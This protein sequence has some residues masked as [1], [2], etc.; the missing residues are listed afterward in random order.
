MIFPPPRFVVVDD[1]EDHL[2]AIRR[3]FETLGAPCL[4]I[5]YKE[6]GMGGAAQDLL[7]GVRVLCLDLHLTDPL[8]TTDASRHYGIIADLLETNISKTGGPFM[9]VVWTAHEG[10][11]EGLGPYLDSA[12]D[13]PLSHVRPLKILPLAKARFIDKASGELLTGAAASLR[14]SLLTAVNDVPQ[15]AALLEWETDTQAATG[16]TLSALMESVPQD[17]RPIEQVAGGLGTVLAHLG[18][19]AAGEDRAKSD[20]RAAVGSA[21]VPLLADRMLHREPADEPPGPW[22]AATAGN[23]DSSLKPEANAKINRMV[24]LAPSTDALGADAWG[25]VVDLPEAWQGDAQLRSR[26]GVERTYL[27]RQEF[28]LGSDTLKKPR[29]VRIGAV[30]DYVLDRPGPLTYLLGA[31][32]PAPM[33]GDKPPASVWTSPSLLGASDE[34]PFELRFSARFPVVATAE[35]V[36]D[37]K[38]IYRLREQLL[39]HLVTHAGSYLSRPGVL[40]LPPAIRRG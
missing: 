29:L 6:D 20:P 21:L 27:A 36:E 13:A 3:A 17:Q 38:P 40:R 1:K 12:F 9:L 31:E 4:G 32:A 16:A 35:E 23:Y 19:A 39:M 7:R 2:T 14:Q 28:R 11:A 18:A 37:W 15:L 22:K 34:D 8:A 10:E 26:F 33:R 5:H 30:C 25:A 24:H